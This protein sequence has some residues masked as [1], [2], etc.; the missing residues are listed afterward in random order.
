MRSVVLLG[1]IAAA[2][3][4]MVLAAYYGFQS[5]SP[6][7]AAP[8]RSPGSPSDVLFTPAELSVYIGKNKGELIYIAIIGDVFDVTSG[9]KHYGPK[10][11]Y[12]HFA[13]RDATRAFATGDS[14]GPGL[15]D[16]VEGMNVDDLQAIAGWHE[17]YVGHENYTRVGRL[18][19]RHYDATGASLNAF[20]HARLKRIANTVEERK[21]ALPLCNSKWSQ[22]D[23]ST[24]WC[25][26]KSGGVERAWVGVPRLYDESL[27]AAVIAAHGA[28]GSPESANTRCVCA[29]VEELA[30]APPY[31]SE[32]PGCAPNEI[33]CKVIKPK[34]PQS[35]S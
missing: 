12:H 13:G 1:S 24:V 30:R 11:G 10:K 32:Y 17:F 25:S 14:D 23:G 6:S 22:A 20:P 4:A 7:S 27:D 34:V 33:K 29:P 3:G 35:S 8:A 15:T 28:E 9:R 18:I 21:K 16:D 31:L 2:L 26:E 19:G 5:P